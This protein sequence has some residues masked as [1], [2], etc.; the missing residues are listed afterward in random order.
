[1]IVGHHKTIES[2]SFHFTTFYVEPPTCTPGAINNH[3][4]RLRQPAQASQIAKHLAKA[5][6]LCPVAAKRDGTWHGTDSR[7][8]ALVEQENK[9]CAGFTVPSH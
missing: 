1:M 5:R 7:Q 8:R 6:H 9:C 3:V 2:A 4:Y